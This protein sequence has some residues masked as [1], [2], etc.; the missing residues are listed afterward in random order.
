MPLSDNYVAAI[1]GFEGYNP[2]PYW[3]VRQWTSGYGTRARG[4]GETIDRQEAERRLQ[5][6]LGSARDRVR[7]LGA[8][9]TPGQEAAL[10]SLTYN[11]GPGWMNAGLGRAVRAGDWGDARSRFLQYVNAGGRP[12]EGLRSRREAEA[13]WF[14]APAAAEGGTTMAT[15]IPS[16]NAFL[17]SARPTQIPPLNQFMAAAQPGGGTMST[18][19]GVPRMTLPVPTLALEAGQSGMP[20]GPDL[21][22]RGFTPAPDQSVPDAFGGDWGVG[23]QAQPPAPAVPP[24]GSPAVQPEPDADA[25]MRGAQAAAGGRPGASEGP[26]YFERLMR[27]PAFL[28]GLSILG[29]APGGNWGPN[30]AQAITQAT[31]AQREQSEYERQQQ[32]RSVMDR[33][34]SEAFP[35]G[36][37][38]TQHPLLSG[39]PPEL[40]ATVYAMGPEQGLPALQ[41]FAF[42]RGQQDLQQRQRMAGINMM[43]G[44]SGAEAGVQP[45]APG[46]EGQAQPAQEEPTVFGMPLSVARQRAVMLDAMGQR[47]EPFEAAIKQAEAQSRPPEAMRT[48]ALKVDQAYRSLTQSLDGYAQLVERTGMSALPGQDADAIA[49]SRT[50][51]LLQLKELYNLGV[52]NGPDLALMEQ[53]LPDPS[54]GIGLTGPYGTANLAGAA[55]RVKAG[56][57]RLKELLKGVRNTQPGLPPV[58]RAEPSGNDPLGIR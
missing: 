3:D 24:F 34:W 10:T 39:M 54:V 48:Q 45:P 14:D 5:A 42:F 50:N 43:F 41:R 33:V 56:V 8:T 4:P 15:P 29:T 49:Q 26:G 9:M 16:L 1:K 53:M 30:A 36:Q 44:G 13:A 12:L 7:S 55:S 32:Q 6:E 38:N 28:A 46:A 58:G 18:P 20:S 40:A 17:A 2:R 57:A 52:L 31:R 11:A 23:Q 35:D 27:N 21:L 47:N 51:I 22:T 37:P 25:I 19:M